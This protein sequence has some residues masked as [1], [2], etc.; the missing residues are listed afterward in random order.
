[1]GAGVFK[2]D[3]YRAAEEQQSDRSGA[4]LGSRQAALQ[5]GCDLR[6]TQEL[7]YRKQEEKYL[8]LPASS[9][10]LGTQRKNS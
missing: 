5:G 3:Y 10:K 8:L 4:A 1:M 6:G 7:G 9:F 2:G